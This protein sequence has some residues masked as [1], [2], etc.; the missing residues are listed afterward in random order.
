M[1]RLLVSVKQLTLLEVEGVCLNWLVLEIFALKKYHLTDKMGDGTVTLTM[2][3]NG[4]QLEKEVHIGVI[5]I[6]SKCQVTSA[7][8][9]KL[10]PINKATPVTIRLP[11]LHFL[12]IIE[13]YSRISIIVPFGKSF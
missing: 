10:M 6:P 5:R 8:H 13:E 3:S 12:Q 11:G 2:S 7:R 4:Q 9:I 1:I